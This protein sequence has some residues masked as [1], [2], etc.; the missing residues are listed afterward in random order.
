MRSIEKNRRAVSRINLFIGVINDIFVILISL[1][2]LGIAIFSIIFA[3]KKDEIMSALSHKAQIYIEESTSKKTKV[4]IKGLSITAEK[5]GL[6]LHVKNIDFI[7]LNHDIEGEIDEINFLIKYLDMLRFKVILNGEM[8]FGKIKFG[9]FNTSQDSSFSK[10]KTEKGILETLQENI[11]HYF[12]YIA[13]INF[14]IK[15]LD[16]NIDKTPILLKNTNFNL[17]GNSS[18]DL[19]ARGLTTMI[20]DKENATIDVNCN[21]N[22]SF[23]SCTASGFNFDN[24]LSSKLHT[25]IPKKIEEQYMDLKSASLEYISMGIKIG[26][27]NKVIDGNFDIDFSKASFESKFLF[28]KAIVNASSM[29]LRSYFKDGILDADF[30]FKLSEGQNV[31]GSLRLKGEFDTAIDVSATGITASDIEK[32]WPNAY[33]KEVKTWLVKSIPKVKVKYAKVHVKTPLILKEDLKVEVAFSDATLNYASGLPSVQNAE[34]EVLVLNSPDV[35]VNVNTATSKGIN[36]KNSKAI[37]NTQNSVIKLDLLLNSNFSNVLN[38]FIKNESLN[39]ILSETHHGTTNIKMSFDTSV[40]GNEVDI[41]KN[42]AFNGS[43][44]IENFDTP[45]LKSSKNKKTYIGFTKRQAGNDISLKNNGT[46]EFNGKCKRAELDNFSLNLGINLKDQEIYI[47]KL[48]LEGKEFLIKGDTEFTYKKNTDFIHFINLKEIVACENN[49]DL[50]YST[51]KKHLFIAGENLNWEKISALPLSDFILKMERESRKEDASKKDDPSF[52]IL[53]LFHNY[54]TGIILNKITA[55]NDVSFSGI[56]AL[57]NKSG[58]YVSSDSFN[59]KKDNKELV[60]E[61][62]NLGKILLAF[63]KTPPSK[64]DLKNGFLLIKAGVMEDKSLKGKFSISDYELELSGLDFGSKKL[65]ADLTVNEENLIIKELR[66][67]NLVHAIVINGTINKDTYALKLEALYTP[68]ALDILNELPSFLSTGINI[69]TLGGT[70]DGILTL[71]Y[72]IT[73]TLEKPVIQFKT[74]STSRRFLTNTGKITLGVIGSQLI[75]LPLL[76][77]LI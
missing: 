46:L 75:L 24:H 64:G 13:Q 67:K 65:T 49:F 50:I 42:S 28:G 55:F 43:I 8:K 27:N 29:L 18:H 37:Y 9:S 61:A 33:L 17:K 30:K 45:I 44:E 25:I 48:H 60:V 7:S 14:E 69:V 51:Q 21:F 41:F 72:E 1:L 54:E 34:G 59:A 57:N 39:N 63:K 35:L 62:S 32:Y 58:F 22:K 66:M 3:V 12:K 5:E 11:F 10:F 40:L 15:N 76:L 38:F 2:L 56:N 52:I 4:N 6:I 47:K 68:S 19:T 74:T 20:Q 77:L 70:K 71:N 31:F 16:I 73:G 26:K 36:V 53:N 23:F